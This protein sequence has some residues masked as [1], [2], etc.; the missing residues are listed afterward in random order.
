MYLEGGIYSKLLLVLHLRV[1]RLNWLKALHPYFIS[2]E[3]NHSPVISSLQYFQHKP[4]VELPWAVVSSSVVLTLLI[5]VFVK[6][7]VSLQ[8]LHLLLPVVV[9]EGEA[10]E[11]PATPYS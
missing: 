1:Q 9:S 5:P 3:H 7:Q 4:V 10:S 2:P 8:S 11:P 6:H